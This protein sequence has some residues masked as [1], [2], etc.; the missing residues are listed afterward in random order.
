MKSLAVIQGVDCLPPVLSNDPP[1]RSNI[2]ETL[3]E[4]VIADLGDSSIVSPYLIVRDPPRLTAW[5]DLNII[6]S[7]RK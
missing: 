5:T 1:K 4:F 3:I 7:N 2:R 6:G